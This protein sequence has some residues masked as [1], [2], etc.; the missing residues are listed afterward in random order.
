MRKT[1]SKAYRDDIVARCRIYVP[2]GDGEVSFIDTRDIA[3]VAGQCLREAS[4]LGEHLT[5]TGPERLTFA[6]A[7]RQL[8]DGLGRPIRYQPASALG[9][10]CH[11]RKQGASTI[12]AL[13]QTI[14]HT[15]L[16]KGEGAALTDTVARV[17]GR[18]PGRLVDY[19]RDHQDCW[20]AREGE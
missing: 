12:Q 20:R 7:A 9:Y 3:A 10:W 11:L 5:L 6:E 2:A 8:S 18:P 13:V 1:S 14:L 17:L 19:F 15:G 4:H 16:R